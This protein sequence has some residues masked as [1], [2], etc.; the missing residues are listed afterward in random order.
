MKA[1]ENAVVFNYLTGSFNK[2]TYSEGYHLRLPVITTPIIYETRTRYIEETSNTANRDL[3]NVDFQIRVLY[4]PDQSK[5]AEITSEIGINYAEKLLPPIVKEV[6]KTIIAQYSAQQLVSNRDLVSRDIKGA[7]RERL[8]NFNIL[9]DEV[10]LTHISFSKEFEKSV[11]EKQ[12]AQQNAERAKY[13]VQKSNEI[14][15]TTI[16]N[17]ERDCKTI[18][19]I[20]KAMNNSPSYL[21]LKKIETAQ[22]VATILATSRNQVL[23]N[24]DQ[25]LMNIL[26]SD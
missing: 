21:T 17:A 15:K 11:E 16:I 25:L 22:E 4:K 8:I 20:G 12:I 3:Q 26:K 14:K 2:H 6:A 19:L 7:L 13:L 23:L 9:L 24:S 18:E 10:T 5:L 1:G